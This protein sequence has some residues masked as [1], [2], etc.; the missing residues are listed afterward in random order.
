MNPN[1]I[2]GCYDVY[3]SLHK[4]P[5]SAGKRTK[6]IPPLSHNLSD[7]IKMLISNIPNIKW[8]QTESRGEP[9]RKI[10]GRVS[11]REAYVQY[12]LKKYY[13]YYEGSQSE[14]GDIGSPYRA[15]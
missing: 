15:T 1:T 9:A 13:S 7:I 6:Y 5:E 2:K 10:T 14:D 3:N 4:D 8:K 11:T 12:P